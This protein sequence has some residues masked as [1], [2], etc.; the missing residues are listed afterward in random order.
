M[1]IISWNVNGIHAA[2]RQGLRDFI[3]KQNADIYCFQEV[4]SSD[5]KLDPKIRYIPGYQSYFYFAK[6]PGYS[7]TAIYSKIKPLSITRGINI[8]KFDDEGR[9]MTFEL[10]KFYLINAYFPHSS[11]DLSRLKFKLEFNSAFLDYCKTLK[12]PIVIASDFNVAHKDI[13]LANPK[14]NMKNAGFTPQEREW[15]AAFINQGYIDSFREFT[16]EAGNYTWW[17]YRFNARARNIGWRIDYFI[18]SKALRKNLKSSAILKEIEGS[19][20]CPI[21]L[22]LNNV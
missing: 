14:Q 5:T 11:R 13:D 12:K 1:Q 2:T 19:D 4:K 6:K 16:Q 20:H 18:I 22:T 15:F 10:E 9:V 21:S 8:K 3:L 17:T 7:G